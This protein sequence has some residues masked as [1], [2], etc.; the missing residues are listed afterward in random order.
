MPLFIAAAALF[1]GGLAYS[2]SRLELALSD[3]SL[4]YVALS[5]LVFVPIAFFYGA[6]N[7]MV[8]ARGAGVETGFA[9]A[10]KVSCVAQFAEF[11]PIP[12]GA[13]VRTT[14]G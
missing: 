6:V 2:V 14:T 12:G 9:S 7:F 4:L 13:I 8:M 3:I 1:L 5:A 10:F 11:L